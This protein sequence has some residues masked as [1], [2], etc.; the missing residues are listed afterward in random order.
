MMIDCGQ[1]AIDALIHAGR[2]PQEITDVYISHAHADHVGALEELAFIR[3]DW[4]NRPKN[5]KESVN[6]YA[7]ELRANAKLMEE[8]WEKS[9]RGGLESM[10]GFVAT[11]D[12][13]YITR[14]IPDNGAFMWEGWTCKPIQQVHIMTGSTIACTFGLIMKK[15]GHKSVYFTTDSQHVSPRQME[16]FYQEADLVFQDSE[17]SGIDFSFPEGRLIYK[18]KEGKVAA[19]PSDTLE[20]MTLMAEG[21][22]QEPFK[23]FKFGSGVHA[24]YAQLAGYD[25]ANS[26]KLP[27]NIKSKMWLSHYQDFVTEGKDMFGNLVNWDEQAKADGF[28]GFVKVGQVFEA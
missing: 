26:V 22:Q 27:A 9:L 15:A 2:K 11:L 12:T 10:E 3:Y 19:W 23:R 24:N 8:L 16:V 28:A 18:N 7:P 17:C 1:K 5:S 25:S 13:F 20:A 21:I 4:K 14:P 6:H